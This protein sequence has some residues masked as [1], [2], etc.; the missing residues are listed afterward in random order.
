MAREEELRSLGYD[1]V[2]ITS[3]EW[4]SMEE[5]KN[6]YNTAEVQSKCTMNDILDAVRND[7]LY[8]F[9]QCSLHVPEDD[10]E[11]IKKFSEFPPI[12]K[13]TEITMNDVGEHVSYTILI[14]ILIISA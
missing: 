11:M 8:G 6:W 2:S 3:C 9:V 10:E 1:I 5:S 7:K 13:N 14:I 4:K 12:F